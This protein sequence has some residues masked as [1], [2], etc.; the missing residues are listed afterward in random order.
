M[1][2]HLLSPSARARKE[3]EAFK[4]ALRQ[5][6]AVMIR[7][8]SERYVHRQGPKALDLLIQKLAGSEEV[9]AFWQSQLTAIQKTN[10]QLDANQEPAP[11]AIQEPESKPEP[12]T[13]EVAQ[14]LRGWLPNWNGPQREAS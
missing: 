10:F 3:L 7:K 14:K 12:K 11:E 1:V 2:A 4:L 6:D 13:N 9:L 5:S 8:L